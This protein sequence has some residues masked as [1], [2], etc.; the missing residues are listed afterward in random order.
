MKNYLCLNCLHNQHDPVGG[1]WSNWAR[2]W[3]H[4]SVRGA[5]GLRW[6]RPIPRVA[7]KAAIDWPPPDIIWI[8]TGLWERGVYTYFISREEKL[9]F[10]CR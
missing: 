5:K 8:C 7:K 6:A 10:D 4:V 1:G 2:H 9:C 3:S